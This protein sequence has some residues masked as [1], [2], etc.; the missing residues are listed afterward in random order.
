MPLPLL[1]KPYSR[2]CVLICKFRRLSATYYVP[3][4]KCILEMEVVG[5][6][7]FTYVDVTISQSECEGL[8]EKQ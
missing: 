6:T 1:T 5:Q 7:D 3:N 8:E 2:Q 4:G